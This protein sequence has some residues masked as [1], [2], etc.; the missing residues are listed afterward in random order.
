[1]EGTWISSSPSS[2]S[3]YGELQSQSSWY[4]TTYS[5]ALKIS[6]DSAAS[7]SNLLQCHCELRFPSIHQK[8]P[9]LQA[10]ITATFP[11]SC[12]CISEKIVALSSLQSPNTTDYNPDHISEH[13][14]FT[15]KFLSQ[16]LY[17]SK[18]QLTKYF[19]FICLYNL[20]IRTAKKTLPL[21]HLQTSYILH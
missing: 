7:L 6:E 19:A 4:R 16:Q 20:P 12:Q 5:Q 18:N 10:V 13:T 3:T 1:M 17:T 14:I 15:E 8:C 9:L 2:L 21:L 11:L